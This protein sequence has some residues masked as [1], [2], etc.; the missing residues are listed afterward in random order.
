M[1]MPFRLRD[2]FQSVGL[3]GLSIAPLSSRSPGKGAGLGEISQ[4]NSSRDEY[5]IA[6]RGEG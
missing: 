2:N 5:S 4:N 1:R 6:Y 3:S